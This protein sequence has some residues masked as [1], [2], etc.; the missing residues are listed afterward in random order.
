MET[1]LFKYASDSTP[2][3]QQAKDFLRENYLDGAF[4]PC[5]GQFVK[6]YHRSITG[7]MAMGLVLFYKFV[8]SRGDIFIENTVDLNDIRDYYNGKY[9]LH[10]YYGGDFAKLKYWG[11][12]EEQEAIRKDGS[13]RAGFWNITQKGVDF[14]QNN[15]NVPR[16]IKIYDSKFI[17]YLDTN[18][19]VGI[20]YCLG[21]KFNYR[22]LMQGL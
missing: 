17:G 9:P 1:A 22:E 12:I 11:L 4:C 21:K 20:E 3:L 13:N 8:K 2:T 18:D 19:T 10:L 6:E 5:C 15:I 7:S 16:K 14:V